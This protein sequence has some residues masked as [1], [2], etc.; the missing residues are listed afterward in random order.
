M[1]KKKIL[2]LIMALVMLVG[3]FSPLTALAA[4]GEEATADSTHKTVIR[5]HK[6][7]MPKADMDE[8][9]DKEKTP[10]YDGTQITNIENYFTNGKEVKGVAFDIYEEL[11]ATEEGAIAHNDPVLG[12]KGVEGKFYKKVNKKPLITEKDGIDTPELK[13]GAYIIVENKE[14][15]KYV[16]LDDKNIANKVITESKAIPTRIVLPMTKPDGSKLFGT[17]EDKLHIY[18]K[19]T[20]EKPQIDKNFLKAPETQTEEQKKFYNNLTEEQKNAIGADY[21]NYQAEKE[22]VHQAVGTKVPYEVKTEIPQKSE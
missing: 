10:K 9:S 7:V 1:N 6:I 20:E 14:E 2:S 16:G 17:G 18:P 15:S 12:D 21:K 22:K 19:N 5:I 4:D 8:H 11:D 13:N 3:V